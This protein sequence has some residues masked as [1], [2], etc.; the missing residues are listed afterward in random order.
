MESRQIKLGEIPSLKE[1]V[2]NELRSRIIS[3]ELPPGTKMREED[4][5]KEYGI[6]RAPLREAI[7]MLS[8]DGFA[9]LIPRRGAIVSGV[10]AKDIEDIWDVREMVEPD[11]A[12]LALRNIDPNSLDEVL[13]QLKQVMA[14]PENFKFYME[15]DILVHSLISD[16]L[17]NRYLSD[18]L[19]NIKDHSLRLRWNAEH[20]SEDNGREIIWIATQ[21][22]I[23]IVEAMK[24]KDKEAVHDT[25]L[26]H[27]KESRKR[28]LGRMHVLF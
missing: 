25:M 16:N 24:C 14:T 4:L 9:H 7:N 18:I 22:H 2:Y 8:R 19:K 20:Q 5:A 26:Y 6:S 15:S 27:L 12:V 13:K 10:E 28:T 21:E 3:G 23:Q 17:D 11:A 1:L